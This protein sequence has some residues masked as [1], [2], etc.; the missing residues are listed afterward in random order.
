VQDVT[1]TLGVS[2]RRACEALGISR[3]LVRYRPTRPHADRKL[4]KRLH[5]LSRKNPRMGYR[6][7]TAKLRREG[8]RVNKKRVA[9]L[10]RLH[11]LA[12]PDRSAKRRL[13]PQIDGTERY[14]AETPH[15]VWAVDFLFDATTD[16]GV[17]KILTVSDEFTK[18]CLFMTAARSFKAVDVIEAL[19]RLMTLYGTPN[20]VR[21]DNG[22]EFVAKAIQ[23]FLAASGVSTM[24]IEPGAP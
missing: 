7:I 13:G 1:R 2:E 4:V 18:A 11:G 12:V 3:S 16:G 22:P 14:R 10:W 15:D 19:E 6:K 21:S 20:H 5:E 17:L 24:F 9:R 8:W 23:R